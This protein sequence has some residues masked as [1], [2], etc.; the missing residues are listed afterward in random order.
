LRAQAAQESTELGRELSTL[1]KDLATSE[2]AREAAQSE[3]AG[4]RAEVERLGRELVGARENVGDHMAGL[5]QAEALLAEARA[6]TASL[7]EQ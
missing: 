4:M 3:A 6:L 5:A 2:V 1:R 7:R